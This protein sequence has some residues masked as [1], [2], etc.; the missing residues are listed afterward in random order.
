MIKI[1]MQ[2][3]GGRGSAGG[4]KSGGAAPQTKLEKVQAM[5]NEEFEEY[6]DSL[7]SVTLP[8]GYYTQKIALQ[9]MIY[10]LELN[11]KPEMV[12]SKAEFD[13][14]LA[15]NPDMKVLYR[16]VKGTSKLDANKIHD[17]LS[18]ADDTHVG[19][20]MWGDGLYFSGRLDTSS[21]PMYSLPDSPKHTGEVIRVA[22]NPEAK[23]ISHKEL[24][25]IYNSLPSST[26]EALTRAGKKSPT[27]NKGESQLALK[28][29][30]DAIKSEAAEDLIVLN[31]KALIVDNQHYVTRYKFNAVNAKKKGYTF[32]YD[33]V[34]DFPED[35]KGTSHEYTGK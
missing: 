35:S 19:S 16:G 23:I 17:Q 28:L 6:L 12:L 9:K 13:K 31:R 18:F 15:D 33:Q 1:T 4:G 7:N 25:K 30:Y 34:R 8:K 26:Q 20:G 29:G 21:H 27:K 11:D 3:F 32:P 10:D 24:D 2:F 5:S 14:M 22:L